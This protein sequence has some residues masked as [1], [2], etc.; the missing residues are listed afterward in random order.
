MTQTRQETTT[1]FSLDEQGAVVSTSTTET[2]TQERDLTQ[3][4]IA[5]CP[6]LPGAINSVCVG[7]VP[8]LGYAVDPPRGLHGRQL[9]A[10]DHH[11]RQPG[12]R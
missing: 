12:W 6:L 7:D 3:T 2:E 10:G 8:H 9:D 11:V 1:V 4:E 5:E